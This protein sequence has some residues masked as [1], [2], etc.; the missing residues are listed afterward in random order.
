MHVP[1]LERLLA[2]YGDEEGE[3]FVVRFLGWDRACHGA[4]AAR[5]VAEIMCGC[6][7]GSGQIRRLEDEVV[8]GVIGWLGDSTS[9]TLAVR[10]SA[11]RDVLASGLGLESL[12]RI[13]ESLNPS[14]TFQP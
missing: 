6:V 2:A 12:N 11:L 4:E 8:R 9:S 10:A 14:R 3:S 5:I 7:D 13:L 1:R